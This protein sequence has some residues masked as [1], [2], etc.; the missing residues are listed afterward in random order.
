[1]SKTGKTSHELLKSWVIFQTVS[2]G[3]P[4]IFK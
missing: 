2:Q 3:I 1:M 4:L